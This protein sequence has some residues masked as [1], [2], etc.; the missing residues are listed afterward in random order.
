MQTP[1][2]KVPAGIRTVYQIYCIFKYLFQQSYC[3]TG[4]KQMILG[5]SMMCW[6]LSI[7]DVAV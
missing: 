4:W 1:L 7:F 2:K 6:L 5:F 3:K